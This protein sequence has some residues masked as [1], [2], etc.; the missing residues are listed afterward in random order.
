MAHNYEKKALYEVI[1]KGNWPKPH[2][3]KALEQPPQMEEIRKDEHPIAKLSAPS[4]TRWL[5][6]PRIAQFNAGRIELSVPYQ[7]AIAMLLGLVLLILVA[8]RLGQGNRKIAG[9]VAKTPESAQKTVTK[10]TAAVP[11]VV[12]PVRQTQMPPVVKQVELAKPKGENRIVIQSYQFRADLEPVRQYFAQYGI[13]TEIIKKDAW[14]YLVTKNKYENPGKPGTDGYVARQ[15]IVELGANYKAP[16]G[17][18]TFGTKPFSDAYGKR[19][20]D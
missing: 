11:R 10:T 18:E 4:R 2:A 1:S 13:E 6:K 17:Y 8:F 19:F 12:G 20:D 9:P 5:N 14:Y 16:T 3:D 7:I 15:K